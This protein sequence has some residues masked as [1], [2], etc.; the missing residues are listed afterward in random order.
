MALNTLKTKNRLV[1]AIE[2][3]ELY[4]EDDNGPMEEVAPTVDTTE[5]VKFG[6]EGPKKQF[7]FFSKIKRAAPA[8]A[9][10]LNS[11]LQGLGFANNVSAN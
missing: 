5:K 8:G 7:N 1:G 11:K 2:N 4:A 10:D 3:T 9:D 6:A